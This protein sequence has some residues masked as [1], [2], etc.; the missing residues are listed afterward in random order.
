MN[1]WAIII[2]GFADFCS[3]ASMSAGV[4][5]ELLVVRGA[6][7]GFDLLVP[8]AEASKQFSASWKSA[9]RKAFATGKAV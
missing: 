7:H 8:D 5:T 6:L 1:R 2:R 9:L 3:K 4:A